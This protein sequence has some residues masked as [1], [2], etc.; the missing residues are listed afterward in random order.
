MAQESRDLEI[1][2]LDARAIRDGRWQGL[3]DGALRTIW[4]GIAFALFAGTVIAGAVGAYSNRP[5]VTDYCKY[6]VPY[7]IGLITAMAVYF[8]GKDA[9][10]RYRSQ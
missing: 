8:F 6:L 4:F 5:L 3:S 9:V 2:D 7:E 1:G 10:A